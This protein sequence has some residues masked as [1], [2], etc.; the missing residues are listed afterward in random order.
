MQRKN[1]QKP[2]PYFPATLRIPKQ[3][4][5]YKNRLLSGLHLII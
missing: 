2:N 5:G 3:H 1:F 4:L